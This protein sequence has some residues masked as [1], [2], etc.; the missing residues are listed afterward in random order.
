LRH[1]GV[2]PH[3]PH[4]TGPRQPAP[5]RHL[6]SIAETSLRSSTRPV[7]PQTAAL[8]RSLQSGQR[9]KITQRV[10]IGKKQWDTA[11]TGKFRDVNFLATGLATD[12]VKE[13]DI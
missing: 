5:G 13:D 10:R 6:M 9:V 3:R 7:D 11:V 4:R 8:L 12:R 2:G 1:R